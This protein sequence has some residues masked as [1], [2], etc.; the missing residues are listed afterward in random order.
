MIYVLALAFIGCL[1]NLVVS[2]VT[3][4][5]T[6]WT[7]TSAS[8]VFYLVGVWQGIAIGME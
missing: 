6:V 2:L 8:I 4:T 3:M 1:T 5:V 7:V